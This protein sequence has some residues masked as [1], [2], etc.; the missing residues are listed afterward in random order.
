MKGKKHKFF[1]NNLSSLHKG[2]VIIG[3]IVL[4]GFFFPPTDPIT[5]QIYSAIFDAIADPII[6]AQIA[7]IAPAIGAE[8][9]DCIERQMG[10]Y[11]FNTFECDV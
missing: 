9:L 1:F 4:A 5:I 8:A 3:V 11:N 2:L 7:E 6:E 10:T